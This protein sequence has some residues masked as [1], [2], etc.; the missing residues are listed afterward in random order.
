LA[1][2]LIGERKNTMLW[3]SYGKFT[4]ESINGLVSNPQNR[5]EAVAK[6]IDTYGGEMVS[7]HML[8][9]GEIDFIIFSEIP[10][11]RAK[12]LTLVN[13]LVVRGAGGVESVTT[14]PAIRAE[15]A[16]MQME[17]AQN[18]VSAMAYHTPTQT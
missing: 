4:N 14:V 13:A 6:L 9:N 2:S 11:E 3:V 5:A 1:R 12:D 17:K 18:L 8:L 16:V 10:E 15:D 7:Y